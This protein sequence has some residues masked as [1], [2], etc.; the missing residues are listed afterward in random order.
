MTSPSY[1]RRFPYGSH[2]CLV[3]SFDAATAS[4]STIEG[5]ATGLL[6]DGARA[7]G[8]VRQTRPLGL[9]SDAGI[10]TYYAR[11]LIRPALAD[12]TEAS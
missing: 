5:N 10:H 4:F 3:E 1:V 11:R 12:L 8:V 9:P 7:Q 2:V 6:P